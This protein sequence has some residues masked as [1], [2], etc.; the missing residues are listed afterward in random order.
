MRA[1]FG[2]IRCS[3]CKCFSISR[4]TPLKQCR[5]C[6]PMRDAFS[7]GRAVMGM[8]TFSSA[9]AILVPVFRGKRPRNFS[10]HS[11]RQNPMGLEWGW[12]FLA[13]SSRHTAE[14]SWEKIVTVAARV[15]QFVYRRR[16]RTTP[17]PPSFVI[18]FHVKP[19]V[20]LEVEKSIPKRFQILIFQR[21]Q[22]P[23]R[24]NLK[25]PFQIFL[26]RF[27]ISKLA[28]I[29]S[30]IVLNNCLFGEFR[31]CIQQDFFRRFNRICAA[32]CVGKRD[33]PLYVVGLK[34]KKSLRDC[35]IEPFHAYARARSMSANNI[36]REM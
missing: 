29:T 10:S 33:D 5:L 1:R 28:K 6:P 19:L 34:P 12:P 16:R 15:S 2:E 13:A 20:W 31:F 26:H 22:S 18:R 30:K 8:E 4:S 9:C 7:S 21:L 36:G 11:F 3:S 23:I 35:W 25:R 14:P 27:Q 17:K 24:V 32:Y